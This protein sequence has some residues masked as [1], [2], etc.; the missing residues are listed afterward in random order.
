MK[1][2]WPWVGFG[3]ALAGAAS[4]HL[5]LAMALSG[6]FD[7]TLSKRGA[8]AAEPSRVTVQLHPWVAPQADPLIE[9][10]DASSM[11]EEAVQSSAEDLPA[12]TIASAPPLSL[13]A[14]AEEG[15]YYFSVEEV[16]TPAIPNPDW[17]VDVALLLGMGVRSF[18]VNVLINET[19]VAELCTITR[20]EP[21]QPVD[22]R[23]LV[24]MKLCETVLR[25]AIRRGAA[26][27]S[28]RH[29]EL[30]LMAPP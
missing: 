24:E 6:E 5:A 23:K 10:T 4:L 29:I 17:Q 13:D 11:T 15:R 14:P 25:P 27:P 20:M 3:T 8:V 30:M 16:D 21:E 2:G 19:G 7:G 1:N 18:N 28:V 9:P 12:L 26:V 22:L